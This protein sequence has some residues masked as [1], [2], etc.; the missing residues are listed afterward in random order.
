LKENVNNKLDI[1]AERNSLLASSVN[2]DS[3]TE[4]EG[5]TE[6]EFQQDPLTSE[7]QLSNLLAAVSAEA[8]ARHHTGTQS[9]SQFTA[10]D[11][12]Q[13]SMIQNDLSDI[14]DDLVL[15][16]SVWVQKSMI[17]SELAVSSTKLKDLTNLLLTI[18]PCL[19]QSEG[20]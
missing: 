13:I 15:A 5:A 20:C 19:L 2:I 8:A 12:P 14:Y 10:Y 17:F 18:A 3:A 4:D 9:S 6:D 7:A 11:G 16:Y 1:I